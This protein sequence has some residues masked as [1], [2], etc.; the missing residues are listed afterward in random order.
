MALPVHSPS[1]LHTGNASTGQKVSH[2]CPQLAIVELPDANGG[3][4]AIVA[5]SKAK[6]QDQI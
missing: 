2:E 1:A 6:L 5:A 3:R 4:D